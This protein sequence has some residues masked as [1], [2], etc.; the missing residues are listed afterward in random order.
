MMYRMTNSA[1]A[2]A[3]EIKHCK[4]GIYSPYTRIQEIKVKRA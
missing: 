4:G 1:G 3:P 2:D